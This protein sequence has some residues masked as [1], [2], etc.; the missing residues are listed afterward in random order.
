MSTEGEESIVPVST[1]EVWMDTWG[2]LFTKK[3]VEGLLELYQPDA[4]FVG[5]PK[6]PAP[7][8]AGLR[9]TINGFLAMNGTLK[10]NTKGAV[11]NGDTAVVYGP[12]IFDATGP[13][14]PV[15]MDFVATAVLKKG[16]DGWR[17]TIDDF[18][19]EG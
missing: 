10:L 17:A 8:A 11:V 16:S 7:I 3:D 1:P 12:W 19:S 2:D 13:E 6:K 15:H 5:E 9:E 14:G 4:V 18:F